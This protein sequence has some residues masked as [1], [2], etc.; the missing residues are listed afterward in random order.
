MQPLL[1]TVFIEA[2]SGAFVP[3][4][5]LTVR[6]SDNGQ[7]LFINIFDARVASEDHRPLIRA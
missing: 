2:S 7:T 3:P 1:F 4:L 6:F 5:G